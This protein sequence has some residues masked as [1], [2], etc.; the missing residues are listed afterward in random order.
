[1]RFRAEAP[2]RVVELVDAVVAEVAA[3]EVRPPM[4]IV[5]ESVFLKG[6]PLG[7]A[8]PGVVIDAGRRRAGLA[9]A[10]VFAL[11]PVPGF[12]NEDV[13]DEAIVQHG[14][15]LADG[16]IRARLRTVDG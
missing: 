15:G 6:H 10:D 16:R 3:A 12:G 14:D 13:A 9:V 8:D 2:Q 5:A 11:L 7:R 4:P 1:M